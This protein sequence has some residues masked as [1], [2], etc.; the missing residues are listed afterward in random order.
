[1]FKK[2]N[3]ILL[4]W[5]DARILGEGEISPTPKNIDSLFKIC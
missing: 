5:T 2:L 1:M 4:E 3:P